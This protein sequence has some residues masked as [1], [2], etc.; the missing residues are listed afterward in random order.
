MLAPDRHAR[1]HPAKFVS[2]I[3]QSTSRSTTFAPP[4]HDPDLQHLGI[5]SACTGAAY[6]HANAREHT[7]VFSM[8]HLFCSIGGNTI[9]DSHAASRG[10]SL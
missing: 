1:C 9:S 8:Q 3:P 4:L 7:A 6:D 5:S 10:A 2:T